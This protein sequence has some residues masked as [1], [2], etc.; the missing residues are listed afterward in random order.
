MSALPV[1]NVFAWSAF[2]WNV[3]GDIARAYRACSP[4]FLCATRIKRELRIG[5]HY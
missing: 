3:S 5:Y 2:V 4:D 1:L